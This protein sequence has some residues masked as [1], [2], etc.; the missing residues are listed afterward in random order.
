MKVF[1]TT[2]R[3]F[4]V[5]LG[6]ALAVAAAG[7]LASAR[8]FAAVRGSGEL[9]MANSADAPPFFFLKDG[10]L[11]GFE[12]DLGNEIAK[13]MKLSPKWSTLDFDSLLIGLDQDRFDLVVSSV[14][15]TPQRSKAVDF[16]SP[17][18]C[19]GGV[20]IARLDGPITPTALNGKTVAVQVG[21]TYLQYADAIPGIRDVKTFPN[22]TQTLES[23][24]NGRVDAWIDEKFTAASVVNSNK[25]KLLRS[26]VIWPEPAAIAAKKGNA[27]LVDATNTAIRDILADGTYKK[28]SEKWFGE[29][30]RCR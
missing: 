20:I 7:E 8:D 4:V 2:R 22:N 18:Y 1:K 17:H 12:V 21:T 16:A 28:L 30:I 9:R 13:R 10:E 14:S 27:A 23:L 6:A 25:D 19:S 3:A 15:P 26:G 11:T 24:L 29:D 5:V